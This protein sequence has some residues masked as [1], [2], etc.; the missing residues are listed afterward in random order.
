[1]DFD[2]SRM[3]FSFIGGYLLSLAGSLS[4][5]TTNNQ[6]ASPSTLG[7]DG[8]GVLCV[9]FTHLFLLISNDYYPAE[10]I[11]LLIFLFFLSLLFLLFEF[12]PK[13]EKNFLLRDSERS[14]KKVILLG[15]TFNLFVGA[16]FSV[17]QFSFMALNIDF[18]SALWFGSFKYVE[19]WWLW[20]FTPVM[21]YCFYQTRF[22]ASDLESL[23]LGHS[24]AIGMKVDTRKV[25]RK[26]MLLS[27]FTTVLVISFF[28][29]FS[30]LG[31]ILPHILRSF[32]LFSRNLKRELLLGPFISGTALLLIDL[33]C[34]SFTY[35]GAELPVGMVSGVLGSFFLIFLISRSRI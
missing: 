27:L 16:L 33:L 7:M 18:P 20:I 1:M 34:F 9:L 32:G 6:L 5:I 24:F 3:I 10:V 35:Q 4:Q 22:L 29:V 21:F 25:Q 23:N 28:G 8:V 17:F 26:T 19:T 2:I 31:L 15:L 13:K 30:F 14:I 12:M 11:S